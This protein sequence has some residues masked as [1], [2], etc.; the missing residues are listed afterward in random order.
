[1]NLTTFQKK[2]DNTD[3]IHLTQLSKDDIFIDCG[4]NV[5]QETIPAAEIGAVVYAFEPNPFAFEELQE[6]TK[7]YGNVH[8]FN[9][10]VW[11]R[12]T[13]MKLFLHENSDQDELHWSTGS[14]LL[15]EKGNVRKD[16]FVEVEVIDL[17]EFIK[18]LNK[19]IK[20]LKIDV[21]GSEFE[22]LEKLIEE[23]L[24]NQIEHILVETHQQK[25]PSLQD[26]YEKILKLINQRNI[27]NI[28]LNWI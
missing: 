3:L 9:K 20:V 5:G 12:N 21:E 7:S 17:T 16:K 2:L 18:K 26:K 1:M 14:S 13:T 8:L 24:Y 10:A 27:K 11:D 4:A 19:K 28:N 25:I 22:I 23:E 6:Q 15:E